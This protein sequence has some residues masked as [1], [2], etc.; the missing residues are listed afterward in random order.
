MTRPAVFTV[1]DER[2]EVG[3][4]DIVVVEPMAAHTAETDGLTYVTITRPDWFFEQYENVRG[5]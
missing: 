3:E 5:A 4:K 2:F 1:G